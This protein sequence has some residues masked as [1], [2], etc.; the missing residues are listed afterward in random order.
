MSFCL[1][2]LTSM[3]PSPVSPL[4]EQHHRVI[5]EQ[6]FGG[7]RGRRDPVDLLRPVHHRAPVC[8]LALDRQAGDRTGPGGGLL[9][10]GRHCI[11]QSLLQRA[12][13]LR[14]DTRGEGAGRHLLSVPVQRL[15]WGR[16]PVPLHG[17]RVA[18]DRHRARTKL[19][20]DRGEVGHQGRHRQDR[21]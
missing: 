20:E 7:P 3:S 1:C 12:L 13:Q 4:R 18:A 14:G 19:G 11:A 10:S 9:R 15:T 8:R 6:L 5:V 16:G 17:H 21:W 2:V